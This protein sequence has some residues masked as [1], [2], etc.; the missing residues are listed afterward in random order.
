MVTGLAVGLVVDRDLGAEVARR[1]RARGIGEAMGQGDQFG[2][3]RPG[4][5]DRPASYGSGCGV[6]GHRAQVGDH[7]GAL[8]RL[9]KAGERHLGAAHEGLRLEDHVV[10][11]FVGPIAALGLQ[12]RRI[13]EALVARLLAADDVPLVR[14]DLV[15]SALVDGMAG[16]ALLHEDRLAGL[17]IGAGEQ[18]TDRREFLRRRGGHR[19]CRR[20]VGDGNR[21]LFQLVR[22][23]RRRWR[24][25]RP[26]SR[27]GPRP[28][29][30]PQPC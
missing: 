19:R 21:R 5:G 6:V 7:V 1:D 22:D 4:H 20:L 26:P 14:A 3:N 18:G 13:A 11:V 9:G 29:R 2:G 24:P 27:R 10:D 15:R 30:S 12:R 8:L 23:A 25:C 28:E 17:D 16:E